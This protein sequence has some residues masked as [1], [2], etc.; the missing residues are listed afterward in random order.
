MHLAGP[1]RRA[2]Q[3]LNVGYG[4]NLPASRP[5]VSGTTWVGVLGLPVMHAV[6]HHPAREFD[7]L[8]LEL[9]LESP[10]PPVDTLF[11]HL[12]S[13]AGGY[14]D[15]HSL[16]FGGILVQRE[17]DMRIPIDECL[18][19]AVAGFRSARLYV[20]DKAC[21]LRAFGCIEAVFILPRGELGR[22]CDEVVDVIICWWSIPVLQTI[23]GLGT[24]AL[25]GA[26]QAANGPIG[27]FVF[28][29]ISWIGGP[30]GDCRHDRRDD[31]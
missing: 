16:G 29:L 1:P 2:S 19:H 10:G 5:P 31:R 18:R 23:E 14:L 3:H 9:L 20:Y 11:F 22:Q 30:Q 12:S 8:A 28:V 13:K 25:S 4:M 21:D 24:G 15:N 7:P 27:L 6:E 26:F 17:F